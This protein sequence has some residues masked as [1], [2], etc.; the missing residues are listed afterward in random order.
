MIESIKMVCNENE[1]AAGILKPYNQQ[2]TDCPSIS[3][4]QPDLLSVIVN[5]VQIS[6]VVNDCRR[7]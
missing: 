3:K 2:A 6:M 1:S 4:D 7:T 5:I